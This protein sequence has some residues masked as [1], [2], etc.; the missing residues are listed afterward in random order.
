MEDEMPFAHSR[1]YPKSDEEI[2]TFK[3]MKK[4]RRG[5]CFVYVFAGIVIQCIIVLV[6]AFIVSHVKIP[7]AKLRLVTM[8]NVKYN[9]TAPSNLFN[10][11]M[12]AEVTIKNKNF[13]RFKFENSTFRVLY[14]G[15]VIGE[16]K[17]RHG[18][19]KARTGQAMN[20]TVELRSNR[21]WDTKNLSS[22]IKS[23]RLNLSSYANL[24]GT[25]HV[26]KIIKK[27]KITE[28]SCTMTLN[29]TSRVVQDLQC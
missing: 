19:V 3:A 9:T 18:R 26:M 6:L 1:I 27:R 14:E 22:D 13:G 4:E 16:R 17:L 10:A 7:A 25:V 23:G 8:K 2:A 20:V 5:K 11:T 12:V 28:L 29:L 15:M 21:L 24:S